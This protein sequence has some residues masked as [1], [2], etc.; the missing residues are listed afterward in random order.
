MNRLLMGYALLLTLCL[1][2]SAA[3]SNSKILPVVQAV[4]TQVAHQT[5]PANNPEEQKIATRITHR[6]A[7]I[8]ANAMAL[9]QKN[10][11]PRD[12]GHSVSN[13]INDV[14]NIAMEAFRSGELSFDA[15]PEE[16][17]EFATR[18]SKKIRSRIMCMTKGKC[19]SLL[20]TTETE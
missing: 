4:A 15:T 8:I 9:L 20:P 12:V 5:A 6:L 3:V 17:N 19:R 10:E 13:I 16:I 7:N 11:T 2:L 14:V 18:T 1:P